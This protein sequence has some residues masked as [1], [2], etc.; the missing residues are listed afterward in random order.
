MINEK[1]EKTMKSDQEIRWDERAHRFN[2]IQLKEKSVIPKAITQYICKKYRDIDSV[3]DIGGGSGRYALIFGELVQHVLVTDISQ[4]MIN[5]AE[6]NAKLK[7]L[8]NLNFAKVEWNNEEDMKKIKGKYDLVFASMCPAIR[9]I[10]GINNMMGFSNKYCA[11]NQFILSKDSLREYVDNLL[12]EYYMKIGKIVKKKKD[13]HNDREAVQNIFNELWSRG[14][15]PEIQFF[16]DEND[17]EMTVEEA[18][19]KYINYKE[20]SSDESDIWKYGIEKFSENGVCKIS[21]NNTT[22]LITWKLEV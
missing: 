12:K 20:I 22:A 1:R 11:I 19:E 5:Y 9:S 16:S 10:E 17:I 13:P 2:E 21:K 14:Y 3:L 8:S 7:N 6:D 15:S 4:N 18:K